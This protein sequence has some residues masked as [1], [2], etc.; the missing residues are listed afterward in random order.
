LFEIRLTRNRARVIEREVVYVG[1]EEVERDEDLARRDDGCHTDTQAIDLAGL[2]A[3]VP[4]FDRAAGA[5]GIFLHMHLDPGW[6]S[7][8]SLTLGFGLQRF[9]RKE[10]FQLISSSRFSQTVDLQ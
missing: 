8:R 7:L 10:G 5:V 9:Q 4:V 3:G 2:G 1:F 6:R